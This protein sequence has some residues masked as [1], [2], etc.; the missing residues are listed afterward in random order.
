LDRHARVLRRFAGLATIGSGSGIDPDLGVDDQPARPLIG[1]TGVRTASG[2]SRWPR[3][4]SDVVAVI[5]LGGVAGGL[6]RYGLGRAWPA[7]PN[8]FPWTTLLTNT[9]GAFVLAVV[10]VLALERRP[11]SRYLRPALG[12][13]FCGSYTTFSSVAVSTDL[14]GAHGHPATAALYVLGSLLAGLAATVCGVVIA[15]SLATSARATP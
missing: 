13:G 11:D 7:S 4:R 1:A 8:A 2:D 10:L 6:A 3:I 9:T 14:L 15:R 5:A 12:T